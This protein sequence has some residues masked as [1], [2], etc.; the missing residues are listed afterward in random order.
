[1]VATASFKMLTRLCK[2]GIALFQKA[3]LESCQK[4]NLAV[5]LFFCVVGVNIIKLPG[6]TCKNILVFFGRWSFSV[7]N[8]NTIEELSTKTINFKAW[9]L[10]QHTSKLYLF[11][12]IIEKSQLITFSTSSIWVIEAKNT[13]SNVFIR[14][15]CMQENLHGIIKTSLMRAEIYCSTLYDGNPAKLFSSKSCF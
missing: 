5:L 4:Q 7:Y 11:C 3:A 14:C 13:I 8:S 10:Q 1:M 2:R 9:S 15:I 12:Q 6:I